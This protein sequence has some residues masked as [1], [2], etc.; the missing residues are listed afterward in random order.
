MKNNKNNNNQNQSTQIVATVLAIAILIIAVVGISFA[1]FT[2]SKAGQ[3]TNTITTGSITM[4][5]V[6]GDKYIDIVDA[7]PVSDETGKAFTETSLGEDTN[8]GKL[9]PDNAQNAAGVFDFNV[10]ANI[11]GSASID[12]DI[13][14]T[15]KMPDST[16]DNSAVKVYLEQASQSSYVDTA[17]EVEPTLFSELSAATAAT[18]TAAKALDENTKFLKT[19]TF[20]SAGETT[21]YY[22]FKMWVDKDYG[23]SDT[24]G[25]TFKTSKTFKVSIDVYGQ[26]GTGA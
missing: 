6:E 18:T 4:N 10:S 12:Y 16:L 17:E 7:F 25:D 13:M 9:N 26:A 22:R 23:S 5:Y 1:A 2:Y 8:A 14:V 3:K 19:D 11:T 15:K 20:S 24:T 21:H